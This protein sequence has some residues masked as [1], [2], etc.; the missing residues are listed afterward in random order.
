[1]LGAIRKRDV[2]AHPRVTIQCF[3]WRIFLRTLVAGRE[4]TFLSLLMESGFFE[5]SPFPLAD[6]VDRCIDLER[7]AAHLYERLALQ[8]SSFEPAHEFFAKIA[9]Q[10]HGH[11]ELLALCR[12][13]AGSGQW[14]VQRFEPCATALPDL[15]TGMRRAESCLE[16]IDS[17]N[18]ALQLVVEVETSEI[19][20]LFQGV[21]AATDSRFV[22]E[23][24]A[25]H[26]AT[27][28]HLSYI[29]QRV[30]E[31]EPALAESCQA[32]QA[33]GFVEQACAS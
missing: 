28:C 15:E 21:V 20:H 19:N 25:F 16:Q 4:Q 14:Q 3:G 6:V 30:S 1:M 23:I 12:A 9:R 31:L 5:S 7:R 10:E 11:A 17:L 18:E 13:A 22:R 29:R 33:E 26:H 2:I 8:F 27:R 32:L 24:D